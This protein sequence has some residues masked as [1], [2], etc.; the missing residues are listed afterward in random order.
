MGVDSY[1]TDPK[2]HNNAHIVTHDDKDY[3]N[4]LVVAS[5]PLK[6]FQENTLFFTNNTL[7]INMNVRAGQF[8][9]SPE[10]VYNENTEWATSAINGTWVF[11]RGTVGAIAPHSGSVMIDA[12]ATVNNNTMQIAKESDFNLTDYTSI[13]GW[14][15][16]TDWDDRGT[17]AINLLG[18]NTTTGSQ[19]GT[20]ANLKNYI[21]IGI[22][23][24]W[25]KFT[26]PLINM[27]LTGAT[28]NA[29]RIV[30]IGIVPGTPP[31]YFL[32]EIDIQQKTGESDISTASFSIQPDED[33]WLH[34][35]S[36]TFFFADNNYAPVLANGLMTGVPY[37][38]LLGVN[39][40]TGGIIYQRFQ[41][42]EIIVVEKIQ[43]FSG[44]L[45]MPSTTVSGYGISKDY[46][47]SWVS[48]FSPVAEPIILKAENN[49]KITWT[50][51]EDLSGL[52]IFNISAA[53][54]IEQRV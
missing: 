26:I 47:G 10:T 34:I 53:C 13:T 3:N 20:T 44:L 7:G 9:G 17:K 2:N 25:Q 50:V 42:G 23:N 12:T 40:L 22:T 19:V 52:S 48:F 8:G 14:I 11:N 31:D 45:R 37:N 30:T 16:L 43:Q 6:Q 38:S 49:D 27:G 54:K 4:A 41:D 18:W 46:A 21:N 35:S 33:T 39:S 15:A 36:F 5:H 28:I 24:V 1:I 51:S 32:D 29:F